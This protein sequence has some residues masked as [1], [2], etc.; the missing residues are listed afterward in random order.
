MSSVPTPATSKNSWFNTQHDSDD[1]MD[2]S[3]VMPSGNMLD[4]INL[5]RHPNRVLAESSDSMDVCKVFR[6]TSGSPP[7]GASDHVSPTVSTSSSDVSLTSEELMP[8][9]ER[10]QNQ[11]KELPSSSTSSDIYEP[12]DEGVAERAGDGSDNDMERN[13]GAALGAMGESAM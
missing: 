10:L 12:S 2:L 1:S 4:L 6:V 9:E 5:L 8:E 3:N 7:E 13:V 11:L